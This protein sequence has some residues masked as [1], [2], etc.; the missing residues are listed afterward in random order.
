MGRLEAFVRM[1]FIIKLIAGFLAGIC[2][3]MGLGGGSVLLIYLTV[4]A[5]VGQL[6]AQGINLLFFIPVGIMAIIIYAKRG[7]IY[8][9]RIFWFSVFGIMGTVLSSI[10]VSFF[11][12]S[13]LRKIFGIA[14]ILYG[15]LE[16]FRKDS[17]NQ[18]NKNQIKNK[19][20][21]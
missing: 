6:K 21:Q 14:V 1:N 19:K 2:G 16:I 15:L 18:A 11:E 13:L 12:P 10:I 4:F 9:K 17:K 3:A 7:T 20:T 5:N 8:P